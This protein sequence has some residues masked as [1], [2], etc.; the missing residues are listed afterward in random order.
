MNFINTVKNILRPLA[1]A[2][3]RL[4]L[5]PNFIILNMEGGICSQ[6]HIM[7]V[8]EILKSKGQR[9]IYNNDWYDKVG[10]DNDGCFCRKYNITN[11]FQQLYLPLLSS[12]IVK[13]IYLSFFYYYN[14]YDIFKKDY[15]WM[16]T[17]SPAYIA[18]SCNLPPEFYAEMIPRMFEVDTR[19]LPSDNAAILSDIDNAEKNYGACAVHVRRGDLSSGSEIYGAP[20]DMEFFKRAVAHIVENC[21]LTRFFIFS[22]EPEW[23][24]ENLSAVI[25]QM[26]IVDV[27]ASDKGWCDLFLMS[28]CRHS[29]ISLGSMGVY[30]ALLRSENL[31]GGKTVI[32]RE[33]VRR[34]GNVIP[35]AIVI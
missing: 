8:G 31:R 1:K 22:D 11:A 5:F 35:D 34:M 7:L 18:G 4:H 32:W 6:M 24:R 15:R 27:N 10:T 3:V 30:A 2:I 29:I 12:R 28:R 16:D 17:H 33:T 26:T 19:I 21:P 23:C 9:V 20:C 25:P 13:K 14:G